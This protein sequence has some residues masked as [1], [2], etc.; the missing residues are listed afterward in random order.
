MHQSR[1]L[2]EICFSIVPNIVYTATGHRKLD[3]FSR[4]PKPI[5]SKLEEILFPISPFGITQIYTETL[6][7]FLNKHLIFLEHYQL[8]KFYILHYFPEAYLS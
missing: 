2:S 6:T 4:I 8:C 7:Y 3:D 5:E 1:R